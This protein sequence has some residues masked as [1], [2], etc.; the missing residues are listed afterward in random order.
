MSSLAIIALY[1][2]ELRAGERWRHGTHAVPKRPTLEDL[3]D[4]DR[5]R[6]QRSPEP[7]R[8]WEAS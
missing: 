7:I 6:P 4:L 8:F 1:L 5:R 2:S 3:E